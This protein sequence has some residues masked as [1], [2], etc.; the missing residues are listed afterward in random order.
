MLTEANESSSLS[1][2]NEVRSWRNDDVIR[3]FPRDEVVTTSETVFHS[4][5]SQ[6]RL[7]GLWS[8]CFHPHYT[9]NLGSHS[10][11][12]VVM[13]TYLM[14]AWSKGDI[15][16]HSFVSIAFSTM[17]EP[18]LALSTTICA[19]RSAT[20]KVRA[21]SLNLY[22]DLDWPLR[23]QISNGFKHIIGYSYDAILTPSA[24]SDWYQLHVQ[25]PFV[26]FGSLWCKY[27]WHRQR[28]RCRDSS[29]HSEEVQIY[30]TM[31]YQIP[32]WVNVCGCFYPAV[33]PTWP[34]RLNCVGVK[35]TMHWAFAIRPGSIPYSFQIQMTYSVWTA[36]RHFTFKF[37]K[38]VPSSNIYTTKHIAKISF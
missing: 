1:K 12:D 17:S 33:S 6:Y 27:C 26:Q 3:T 4:S 29:Q 24:Y 36:P 23:C 31:F 7:H 19:Q 28:K 22:F 16:L 8:S 11:V 25:E 30:E 15:L 13:I 2:H 37:D 9:Q 35:S 5:W 32:A 21:P 38:S 10:P 20:I 14:S 18:R 34:E